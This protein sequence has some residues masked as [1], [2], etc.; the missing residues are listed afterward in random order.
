MNRPTVHLNDELSN[1]DQLA[2]NLSNYMYTQQHF[3]GHSEHEL[4][5][6]IRKPRDAGLYVCT[7]GAAAH[8]VIDTGGPDLL[9]G[10]PDPGYRGDGQ[11]VG[12]PEVIDFALE[13]FSLLLPMYFPPVIAWDVH[14]LRR[15]DVPPGSRLEHQRECAP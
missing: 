10:E 15:C 4:D 1:V 3:V 14:L 11:D 13:P 8:F 7:E 12:R 2:G 6:T 5:E 9:F